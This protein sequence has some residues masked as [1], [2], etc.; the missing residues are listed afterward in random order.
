MRHGR[1]REAWDRARKVA[2]RALSGVVLADVGSATHFH[3][4]GVAPV[5]GPRMLRVSQVGLHVFY[6]FNPRARPI[7]AAP[8]QAVF[9]SL[10]A[11]ALGPTAPLR[12]A[13]AL[14]EQTIES[15]LTTPAPQAP[16]PPAAPP[17]KPAA[18]APAARAAS[19]TSAS[20]RP[21][22]EPAAS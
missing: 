21:T 14:V 2:A 9:A 20:L 16:A 17:A 12:I 8:E 10:P 1:E 15:S 6:R 13:T 22:G 5:W 7:E 11:E 3:T 18:D 4:T 19:E